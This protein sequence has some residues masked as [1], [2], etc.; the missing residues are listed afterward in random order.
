MSNF[1][2]IDYFHALFVDSGELH[3]YVAVLLL[4]CQS[5]CKKK[6]I[7]NVPN[8]TKTFDISA[9]KSYIFELLKSR[10]MNKIECCYLVVPRIPMQH[11]FVRC[12]ET[13]Q[14]YHLV[15]YISYIHV[16]ANMQRRFENEIW[17]VTW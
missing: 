2:L 11:I 7:K 8:I 1:N 14:I 9:L 13:V 3:N 15:L 10:C 6:K 17:R 5:D 12:Y 16:L 4:F